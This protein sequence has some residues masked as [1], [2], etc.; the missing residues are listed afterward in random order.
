[1]AGRAEPN[2]S[3]SPSPDD[4][5]ADGPS[6][7]H[8]GVAHLD[9]VHPSLVTRVGAER[10]C[11]PEASTSGHFAFRTVTSHFRISDFSVWRPPGRG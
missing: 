11:R 3:G 1:M 8:F 2:A 6:G 4:F 10:G 7:G 5:T 9:G